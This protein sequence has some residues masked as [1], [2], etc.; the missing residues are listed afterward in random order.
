MFFV[1]KYSSKT[2]F[3]IAIL[4]AGIVGSYLAVNLANSSAMKNFNIA[5]IDAGEIN[6]KEVCVDGIYSNRVSSLT[7]N[8]VA[9]LERIKSWGSIPK[10]RKCSYSNMV[11]WDGMND[12]K[13]EFNHDAIAHI[14]ENRL[15]QSSIIEKAEKLSN[16]KIFSNTKVQSISR[17][18]LGSISLQTDKNYII[19]ADLLVFSSFIFRLGQMV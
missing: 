1:K 9:I 7:P 2:Q 11:V 14:V 10:C 4:G 12:G 18:K 16:I 19:S 17:D 6:S 8:T 13:I 15:I 5:L 3:D